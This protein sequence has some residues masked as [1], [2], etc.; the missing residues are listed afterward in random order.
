MHALVMPAAHTGEPRYVKA[1]KEFQAINGCHV[2]Y[3]AEDPAVRAARL[4][5]E[6][7]A[8]AAARARDVS[9]YHLLRLFNVCSYC[10][11][12]MLAIQLRLH[13][14][15]T[16]VVYFAS[17]LPSVSVMRAFDA[18]LPTGARCVFNRAQGCLLG[19]VLGITCTYALRSAFTFFHAL[20]S[21]LPRWALR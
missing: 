13:V 4:A 10:S 2:V 12:Y 3:M 16:P 8:A 7:T 9:V 19:H 15:T 17:S 21:S 14:Y 20:C 1:A 6:A 11:R 18:G 5:K